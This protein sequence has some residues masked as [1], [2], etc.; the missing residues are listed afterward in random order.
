MLGNNLHHRPVLRYQSHR[1]VGTPP[2]NLLFS[3]RIMN[4]PCAVNRA[5]RREYFFC[6]GRDHRALNQECDERNK[7]R[8]QANRVGMATILISLCL[9]YFFESRGERTAVKRPINP[10]IISMGR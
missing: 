2:K 7:G 5:C 8:N 3:H 4:V 10:N 9:Y 6:A 1:I